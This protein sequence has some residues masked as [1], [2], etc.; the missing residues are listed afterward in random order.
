[1]SSY[2]VQSGFTLSSSSYVTPLSIRYVV[3]FGLKCTLV[4]PQGGGLHH[5]KH[6]ASDW[7]LELQALPGTLSLSNTQSV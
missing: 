7:R 6:Q 2:R 5:N 1:M 3:K 4:P